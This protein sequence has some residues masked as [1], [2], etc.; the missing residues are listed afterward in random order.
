MAE[1]EIPEENQFRSKTSLDLV[2]FFDGLREQRH[3]VLDSSFREVNGKNG[4]QL[5]LRVDGSHVVVDRAYPSLLRA[6]DDAEVPNSAELKGEYRFFPDRQGEGKPEYR[7]LI[8]GYLVRVK[9][10]TSN[11]QIA[12]KMGDT[13]G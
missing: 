2:E 8:D 7:L 9:D 12:I 1:D 13:G 5:Q 3:P 6:K 11:L 10:V 4:E